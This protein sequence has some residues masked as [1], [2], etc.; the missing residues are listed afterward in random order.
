VVTNLRAA[1]AP[2]LR[3]GFVFHPRT[4]NTLENVEGHDR[5]L[6][7]D[8][9]LLIIDATGGGSM[10]VGFP[11]VTTTAPVPVKLTTGTSTALAT[12]NAA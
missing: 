11:F 10:L 5:A 8:A 4:I 2:L 9:G 12:V 3:P 6:L 1:Y 7:A